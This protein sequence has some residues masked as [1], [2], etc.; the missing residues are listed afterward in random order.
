MGFLDLFRIGKIK[1]ENET[2]KQ[3]LQ[4]LEMWFAHLQSVMLMTGSRVLPS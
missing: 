2:L 1:S 4:L 3:K